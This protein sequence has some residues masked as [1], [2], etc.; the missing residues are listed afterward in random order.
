MSKVVEFT[1]VPKHFGFKRV[2]KR[3]R[4]RQEQL[5]QL[6]LFSGGKQVSLS[7]HSPF[8][9]ASMFDEKGE[10]M[11]AR[12][13]Y[14][15]AIGENDSVPDAF[16]NLGIIESKEKNYPKA[17][18]CFTRCL[19]EQPRHFEA[20]YNLANLYA[21]AANFTLAKLHYQLSIEIEPDF[22]NSHF[23]L[24]LT[25]AMLREMEDAILTLHRYRQMVDNQERHQA[26]NLI[27]SLLRARI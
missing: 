27:H 22:P 6:N 7:Q 24:A 12:E 25:Q 14:L 13:L 11:Q 19:K 15:K 17:I 4:D 18:D 9:E 8:E 1:P 10:F 26:D 2:R 3:K 16:C 5:G 21:E 20:H 23:N